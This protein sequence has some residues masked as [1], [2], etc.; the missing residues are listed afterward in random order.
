MKL[1]IEHIQSRLRDALGSKNV[2][3][4][5]GEGY[6]DRYEENESG[7]EVMLHIP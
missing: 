6:V 5:M 3:D 4:L 2:H 7:D 1:T